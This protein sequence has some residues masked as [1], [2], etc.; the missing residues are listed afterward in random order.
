MQSAGMTGALL[1]MAAGVAGGAAVLVLGVGFFKWL[2][3]REGH[4][5]DGHQH[6][7]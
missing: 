5:L 4:D 2:R 7:E 6:E 3:D 1:P